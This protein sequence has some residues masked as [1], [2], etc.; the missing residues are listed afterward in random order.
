MEHI[1]KIWPSAKELAGALE[2]PYTTTH[3]WYRRGGVPAKYDVA[4]IRAAKAKG[5][6]LTL[7]QL[8]EA[9]HSRMVGDND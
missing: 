1:K 2:V 8:A 3:S 7:T 4:I 5:H 6:K 9:R